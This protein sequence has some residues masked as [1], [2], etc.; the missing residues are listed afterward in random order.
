[1]SVQSTQTADRLSYASLA[2]I[3]GW[4]GRDDF[5][6]FGFFLDGQ[7]HAEPPGDLAELGVYKGKS[8]AMIGAFQQP[9]ETFTVVDIFEDGRMSDADNARE[10]ARE[11]E[12]FARADFE[13]YYRSIHPRLPVVVQGLSESIG[14]HAAHG[15]HRFVH[16]DASHLYEHV[17][18]DITVAKSLVR[19]DGIVVLDDYR[20][21]HTPGVSAAVWAE[22]SRGLRPLLLTRNKFYGTWNAATL[23]PE[24]IDRWLD[25]SSFEHEVQMIGPHRVGR[26]WPVVPR[27]S[28]WVPPAAV[29]MA[30][31]VY[32]AIRR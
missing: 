19:H 25:G 20:S 18:R 2:A 31:K 30:R 29:P 4:F 22:V 1:M 26:M 23:W 9:S 7:Q 32:T 10:N 3:P 12:N 8:A 14:D 11:Y 27:W 5:A 16:I 21:P 24:R 17:A 13:R 28:R 6:A 15:T